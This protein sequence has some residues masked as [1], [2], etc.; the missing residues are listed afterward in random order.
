MWGRATE[1]ISQ[2]SPYSTD[3]LIVYFGWLVVCTFTWAAIW[4]SRRAWFR[5]LCFVVN[6]VFSVGVIISQMLTAILAVTYWR[7]SLA[8]FAVTAAISLFLFRQRQ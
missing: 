5:F 7:E 6:Q 8:V 2:F 3:N 4:R 1:F